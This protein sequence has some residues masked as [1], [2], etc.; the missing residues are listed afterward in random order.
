QAMKEML[1]GFPP[2]RESAG[3]IRSRLQPALNCLADT[4]IFI[5]N[6][7]A[8]SD[9]FRVVLLP[10]RAGDIG[11]VEIENDAAVVN[12]QR[13]DK[14]SIHVAFVAVD[15]EVGILPEVIGAVAFAS[16]SRSRI[17]RRGNHR[18]RL[19]AITV[20]VLDGVLLVIEHAVQ[21]L[22]KMGH[23][24]PAIEVVVHENFPVAGDVVGTRVGVVQLS[25]SK[26]SHALDETAQKA[27]QRLGL[28]IEVDEYELFPRVYFYGDQAVSTAFESFHSFEFRHAL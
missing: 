20:L 27:P 15:H 5:L 12:V 24:I 1:A 3:P 9:R 6:S 23:V 4:Q 25:Y 22:M 16:C 21:A 11:K 13:N 8:D 2:Y 10:C 19:Q 14:I 18:T 17:F 26:R 28:G 7:L